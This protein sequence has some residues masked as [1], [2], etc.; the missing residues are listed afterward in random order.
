ML[1]GNHPQMAEP[2]RLVKPRYMGVP[3]FCWG[4]ANC[5]PSHRRS[6]DSIETYG[7]LGYL[8]FGKPPNKNAGKKSWNY[9]E[10]MGKT[11]LILYQKNCSRCKTYVY[12]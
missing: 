2:F 1:K 4:T 9:P 11:S 3:K 5:H 12:Q 7:D 10:M 8:H 6:R